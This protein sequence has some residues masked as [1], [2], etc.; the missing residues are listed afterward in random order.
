MDN[1]DLGWSNISPEM[2]RLFTLYDIGEREVNLFKGAGTDLNGVKVFASESIQDIPDEKILSYLGGEGTK[3]QIQKVRDDLEQRVGVMFVS[4]TDHAHLTP[5]AA[6]RYQMLNGTQAGTLPG[7]MMRSIMQFKSFSVAFI[8]K[9]WSRETM[10]RMDAGTEFYGMKGLADGLMHGNG[11]IRGLMEV[12]AM[13]T[14]FGYLAISAKDLAQGKEP[15]DPEDAGT[16][17]R[18]F[19]QGGAASLFGDYILGEYSR[20]GNSA[21]GTM[22]GPIF[23]E[24]DS[25]AELWTAMKNGDEKLAFKTWQTIQGFTPYQNLF[26]TEAAL[27]YMFFHQLQEKLNPGYLIRSESS[28][29]NRTGQE[30]FVPPSSLIPHGGGDTLFEGLN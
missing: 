26:Y 7:E 3:A 9:I 1:I 30:Y 8:N 6:E 14:L 24:V 16:W 5:G 25:V 15:P 17:K 10:G 4:R 28:L 2:K 20:Y 13:T 18:A 21:L 23:G 11:S 22:A 12:A 19:I 29:R 27:D